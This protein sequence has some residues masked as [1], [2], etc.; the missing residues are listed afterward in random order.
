M[1]GHSKHF[2]RGSERYSRSRSNQRLDYGLAEDALQKPRKPEKKSSDSESLRRAIQNN[3]PASYDVGYRKPPKEFRFAPGISGNPSGRP[4]G[5]KN[6]SKGHAEAMSMRDLILSEADRIIPISDSGSQKSLTAKKG[7]IRSVIASALKGNTRSQKVAFDA[8]QA[9]EASKRKE[10]RY[11]LEATIDYKTSWAERE[12][13]AALHGH[14]LERP[15]PDPD[16]LLIDPSTGKV[17]VRGP[18]SKDELPKFKWLEEQKNFYIAKI[19]A[20]KER[21]VL[22]LPPVEAKKIRQELNRAR[23]LLEKVIFLLGEWRS[24][25]RDNARSGVPDL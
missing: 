14:D 22:D 19:K 17:T 5:T 7:L 18:L 13:L 12:A 15:V 21:P 9:A 23:E 6:K 4:L 25:I 20:L 11:L 3:L 24:D 10:E 2:S 16:H 8:I 1:T